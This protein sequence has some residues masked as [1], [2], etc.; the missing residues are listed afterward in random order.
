MLERLKT[1]I[2]KLLDVDVKSIAPTSNIVQDLGA[3]S[4][5]LVELM[6][7]IKEKFNIEIPDED[8]GKIFTV[9]DII[10]YLEANV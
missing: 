7:I 3:D 6:I 10:N 5:D 1:I 9:Q 2:G 8:I 4:L